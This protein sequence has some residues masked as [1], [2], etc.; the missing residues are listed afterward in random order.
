MI[1]EEAVNELVR[2]VMRESA[3]SGQTPATFEVAMAA[4][5]HD[6]INSLMLLDCFVSI[7]TE[8]FAVRLFKAES[9]S[10]AR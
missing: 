9:D 5:R 3:R 7:F 6:L 8:R 4:L 1:T 2:C 10:V